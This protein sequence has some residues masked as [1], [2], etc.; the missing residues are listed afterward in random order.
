M[1]STSASGSVGAFG[2]ELAPLTVETYSASEPKICRRLQNDSAEVPV[3][4]AGMAPGD[5]HGGCWAWAGRRPCCSTT[6]RPSAARQ[7]GE[8]PIRGATRGSADRPSPAESGAVRARRRAW[9]S[10]SGRRGG[11]SVDAP[12]VRAYH[13]A[14]RD[15]IPWSPFLRV[16]ARTLRTEQCAKSQ[17]VYPVDLGRCGSPCLPARRSY[18][19]A[20]QEGRSG[21]A[22]RG[23]R[24]SNNE[25]ETGLHGRVQRFSTE[26]LILAQDERWRR[27]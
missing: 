23:G 2:S 16:G 21:C 18:E 17:C 9:S 20:P 6:Y 26:S 15:P 4:E 14:S 1:T 24:L 13:G 10:R 11:P 22:A 25:P 12:R 8:M 27:A 7:A 19:T 3:R 5:D